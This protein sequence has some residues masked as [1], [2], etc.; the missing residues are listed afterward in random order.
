MSSAGEPVIPAWST[1]AGRLARASAIEYRLA[2]GTMYIKMYRLESRAA[3]QEVADDSRAIVRAPC[4]LYFIWLQQNLGVGHTFKSLVV[5][6]SMPR[7][8]MRPF[9]VCCT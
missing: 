5:W 6:I 4:A 2:I 9:W 1:I 3:Q 8:L 7:R